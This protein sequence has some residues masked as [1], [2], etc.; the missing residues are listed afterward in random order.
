MILD[1]SNERN[2]MFVLDPTGTPVPQQIPFAGGISTLD[3]RRICL[4]DISK[5]KGDLFLNRI[6]Q[7]L[8]ERFRP[9]AIVRR[10]KATFTRPAPDELRIEIVE[11]T[12]AVIEALAD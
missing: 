5:P 1:S 4:L 6:E 8:L 11:S 10:R 2:A 9:A 7:L 12:D 3:G